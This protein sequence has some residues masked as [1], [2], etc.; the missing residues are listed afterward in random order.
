[1][2]KKTDMV[3][4]IEGQTDR[5]VHFQVLDKDGKVRFDNPDFDKF[6]LIELITE[7]NYDVEEV[8]NAVQT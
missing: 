3:V 5:R 4:K 7:G 1:L 6:E 8:K 2:D